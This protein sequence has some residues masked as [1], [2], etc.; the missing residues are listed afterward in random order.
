MAR[1]EGIAHTLRDQVEGG[2]REEDGE[3][4]QEHEHPRVGIEQRPG[5]PFAI[6]RPQEA[7]G[8]GAPKPRKLS[9]LSRRMADPTPN[10]AATSAGERQLGS[11]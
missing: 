6:R 3:A 2:H 5:K 10:V 7:A 1:I 4:G 11:T 8:S 9:A